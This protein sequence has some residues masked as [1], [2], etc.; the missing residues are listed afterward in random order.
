VTGSAA[1]VTGSHNVKVGYQYYWLRQLDDTIAMEPQLGYRFNRGVP[2]QVTYRLP[3]WSRNSITQLNGTYIQDQYTRGRLTLSGA[4]RWDR[5]SSYAPVEHNGV[6]QTSFLNAEPISIEKTSGVDAYNDISPRVGVG[7]DVFG[8]GKTALK[9]RWGRYLGFASNDPPFTSNNPAATLVASVTRNWTDGNNN[10]VV[11]CN[12]LDPAAQSTPGGD[13]CAVVTGNNANF[14]KLGAA[15]IVDPNL[16][17]GWGVRT[18]DYQTEVTL[19]QEVMPRVS[20]QVG[21][22][23][24]TFHGFFVTQ[25]INRNI[26]TDYDTYT[27]TAPSDPRLPGGGGYPLPV[28]V[29]NTTE[30]AQNFLTPEKTYSPS[31][32]EHK[33]YYDG[34]NFDVNARLRGGLFGSIGTQTGRRVDD[35][36][37]VQPF[38]TGG[39]GP[40]PRGCLDENPWQT[41]IRGLASYTVPKID[42]LVSATVRS[43][44]PLELSINW[45]IPNRDLVAMGGI[46]AP[47]ALA[48]GNT[49][50]SIDDAQHR[51]FADNR[52]TQIDMRFAKVVR[53]GR[54]RTDIGVD[55]WNL[56]NTNYATSYED[57]YSFTD[58]NGGTWAQPTAVYAPRFVRL[59]FTV[60]F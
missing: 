41:T 17:E 2:N 35:R 24:R 55:L 6:S 30:A 38:L 4:L 25:D 50:V 21:Y 16:L 59:N 34:I 5:A 20:A 9:F 12:L 23:H 44:P 13:T 27:L 33:A 43:Q 15:T 14:G 18:H 48:S 46:L 47:G 58:P 31:G 40:N 60:N 51:L 57:T 29:S 26:A 36:C 10:K 52:R 7:Y 11:D 3:E 1:Y 22:N 42:V 53:L 45:Q 19:Q 49:T 37:E 54:T 56:L 8:N 39:G 32:N 28:Y